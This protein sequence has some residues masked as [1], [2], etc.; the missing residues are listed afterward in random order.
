MVGAACVFRERFDRACEPL[1]LVD[2]CATRFAA[3][4]DDWMLMLQAS[5]AFVGRVQLSAEDVVQRPNSHLVAE[6]VVSRSLVG[7][8]QPG[9]MRFYVYNL[10]PRNEG[11]PHYTLTSEQLTK[12]N[13]Q[14]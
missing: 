12:V 3:D 14:E 9:P 1:S 11:Y 13:G 10:A 2:E 6:A 7:G 8:A 4:W 5:D